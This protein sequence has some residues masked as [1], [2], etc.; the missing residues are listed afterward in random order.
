M[1]SWGWYPPH[2]VDNTDIQY[3]GDQHWQK[4]WVFIFLFFLSICFSMCQSICV[5][6]DLFT[7]NPKFLTTHSHWLAQLFYL[8]WISGL[9]LK[10]CKLRVQNTHLIK[11]NQSITPM[12]AYPYAKK[13]LQ[14][15]KKSYSEKN[16]SQKHKWEA[17]VLGFGSKQPFQQQST[18]ACFIGLMCMVV[19]WNVYFLHVQS[20][21]CFS[22]W[23]WRTALEMYVL[24]FWILTYD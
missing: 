24:F 21:L 15:F 16:S 14:A 12:D 1:N 5:S 9:E 13:H 22:A 3:L 4:C 10:N 8:R 20:S 11:L 2:L 23:L 6:V 18:L 17:I 19:L 7:I